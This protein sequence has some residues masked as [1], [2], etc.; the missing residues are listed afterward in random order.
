LEPLDLRDVRVSVNDCVAIREA[1]SEPRLASDT[2]AGD[3]HHA[4]AC[5]FYLDY[6]LHRKRFLER[7]L[8]HVPLHRF[9]GR[10]ECAQLVEERARD[11]IAAVQDQ[12]R[13]AQQ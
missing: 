2:R 1:S 7:V 3:V 4:D 11:Q 5:S 8:V 13:T 6:T 9:D 10:S 12:V